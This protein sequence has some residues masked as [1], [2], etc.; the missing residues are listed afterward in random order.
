MPVGEA[1]NAPH[2]LA[3]HAGVHSRP[4]NAIDPLNRL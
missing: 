1:E 3:L 4:A 2:N